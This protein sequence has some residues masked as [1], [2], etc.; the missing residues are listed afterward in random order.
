MKANSPLIST[1]NHPLLAHWKIK[2]WHLL[3]QTLEHKG[4]GQWAKNRRPRI[5]RKSP[6]CVA[7]AEHC[8]SQENTGRCHSS[9]PTPALVLPT[10]APTNHEKIPNNPKNAALPRP[11]L[12]SCPEFLPPRNAP[13]IRSFQMRSSIANSN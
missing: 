6:S 8:P 13:S 2:K 12:L 9:Q 1:I 3:D 4:A 10:N 7:H 11:P 5:H